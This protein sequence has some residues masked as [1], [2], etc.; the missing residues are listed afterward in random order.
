MAGARPTVL[1]TRPEPASR[2]FAEALRSRLGELRV[3]IS[4]VTRTAFRAPDLPDR[5]FAGLVFT[6]ENAVTGFCRL[7]PRRDIH[8]WCV[9]ERTAGAARKEGFAV[10]RGPG[11]GAALAEAMIAAAVPGP[12]L[13]PH[14]ADMAF[15]IAE[16]LNSAGV[17]TV[18]AV[19][20]EQE[21]LP[22][23]AEAQALLSGSVPVLLPLFSARSARLV[24]DWARGSTAPFSVAAMSEAVARASEPLA[25]G[26]LVVAERPD[27]EAMLDAIGAL[28]DA[29]DAP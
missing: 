29:A 16:R 9:G 17:E 6:S 2:R 24:V 27:A 21:A 11:D 8:A 3:V 19:V 22:P 20:Y 14:G 12:V 23:T 1:L 18:S 26:N 4:P 10:T 7:S 15:D 25:A 28:I 13:W 5:D